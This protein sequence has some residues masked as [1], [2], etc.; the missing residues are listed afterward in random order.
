MTA[1]INDLRTGRSL[2]SDELF[3]SIVHFVVV[4]S[5]ETQQRAE[6][7]TDQ[8]VAFLATVAVSTEPMVPSDDVDK[9]LHAFILH[10]A[11]YAAFC[12]K[13]AGRML[14]HNP[15]PGGPGRSET[16]VRAAALAL[17]TARFQVF[18]DLW[19]VNGASVAQCDSDC[20]RPY[21]S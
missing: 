6:R 11:N 8:A 12:D 9:G 13:H 17:K 5:G 3:S 2:V 21:G 15:A 18:D 16:A 7:I 1:T 10:T 19:T 14:H 4:H 20:G